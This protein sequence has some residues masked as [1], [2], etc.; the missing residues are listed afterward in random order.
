L[1]RKN[2]I[3]RDLGEGLQDEAPQMSARMG[4]NKVRL[5]ECLCAKRN[6]V[7]VQK[8]GFV[9]HTVPLAPKF[10]LKRLQSSQKGQGSFVRVGTQCGHRVDK[11][12][13][14]GRAI[15]RGASPEG[16]AQQRRGGKRLQPVQGA[17]DHLRGIAKVGTKGNKGQFLR[18]SI[19]HQSS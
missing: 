8:P 18:I 1:A 10:G 15:H 6:Q 4:Q 11:S 16:R 9:R 14:A 2:E 13:R 7:H 17:A 3:R 19:H 12:R 5:M